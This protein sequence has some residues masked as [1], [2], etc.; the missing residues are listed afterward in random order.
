MAQNHIFIAYCLF[1]FL[2]QYCEQY[3]LVWRGPYN[4]LTQKITVLFMLFRTEITFRFY[5]KNCVIYFESLITKSLVP[6]IFFTTN[7]NLE[8]EVLQVFFFIFPQNWTIIIKYIL[9][10]LFAEVTFLESPEDNKDSKGSL[11]AS[12]SLLSKAKCSKNF[13]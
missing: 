7:F 13:V 1:I 5:L 3:C 4:E 12:K 10:S 9:P 8:L 11:F 2:S 6:K